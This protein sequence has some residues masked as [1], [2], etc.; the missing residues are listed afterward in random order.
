M[1]KF[2]FCFSLI[3]FLFCSAKVSGQERVQ[4]DAAIRQA[5][6]TASTGTG[7]FRSYQ[8][9]I[10]NDSVNWIKGGDASL[11]FAATNL[12]NWAA[13]GE[14]QIGMRAGVNLF[15]N[16]KKGKRTFENYATIAYGILKTGERKGVKND[17]RL[18][19]TSKLGHQISPKFAYTGALVARTQ[20]APGYRYAGDEIVAK[21]SDF[22]APINLYLSVGMD[23]MPTPNISV[24]LSPVMGR[25]TYVRSDSSTVI[26]AAGMMTTKTDADGKQIQVPMKARH[27]FGGGAL[28]KFN[29]NLFSNRIAYTS[30]LDLFSNYLNKPENIEIL[31]TFNA[32]M[33][34]YR[35]ITADWQLTL[36]YDDNQKTVDPE[37][38]N[39]KGAKIQTRVFTGIGLKYQF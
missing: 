34:L 14:D 16:Y 2:I 22:L 3:S 19:Y 27:D 12:A 7:A 30:Q 25:A 20:M 17:D 28:I 11:T 21:L 1:K 6:Q 5:R 35:N 39:L 31:W 9:F 38:G 24:M 8:R 36:R 13:G 37:T 10:D 33:I 18:H 32:R 26:I 23:Y 29:G 15:A 4:S